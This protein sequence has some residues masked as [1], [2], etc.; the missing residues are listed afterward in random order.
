M[1]KESVD[2]VVP[3]YNEKD[4]LVECYQRISDLDLEFHIIF[5]DNASTDGSLALLKSFKDVTVIE[6][7]QNEGYGAS[8]RDGIRASSA[9]IVIIIDA[10]CEY[11]PE[12][13]PD[14]VAALDHHEVVYTSRFL[15]DRNKGMAFFKTIGNKIISRMFNILFQQN[16]TDLYTG[17]K[18]F[19]RQIVADL[20]ME[21]NGFEHVLEVAARL[22]RKGIVIHEIPVEFRARQTGSSKMS[23]VVETLKFIYLILYYFFVLSPPSGKVRT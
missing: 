17:S 23:H 4:S 1:K 7:E 6:H 13:I 12:V 8:L 14:L 22:A 18:G 16:V 21:R 20:P 5:I 3:V 19:R 9:E 2:I 15:D 11:P 10:D